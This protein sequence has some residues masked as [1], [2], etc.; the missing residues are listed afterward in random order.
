MIKHDRSS[1]SAMTV[2][3]VTMT[4]G[5]LATGVA[6][7][8]SMAGT[9]PAAESAAPVTTS[10]IDEVKLDKFV[11]AFVAVQEIQKQAAEKQSASQDMEAAKARTA[12]TQAKMSDAV[13]KSGLQVDEF[14]AIAQLM[15]QDTDL[16]ARINAKM[17]Q[18]NKLGG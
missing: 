15:L 17:Q 16:R 2:F 5:L 18:R 14:N 6:T 11:D 4:V 8:Q 12:E 10:N 7:A 13:R 3:V 9:E 1:V